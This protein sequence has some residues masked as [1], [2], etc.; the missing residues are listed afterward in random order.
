[1]ADNF[2]VSGPSLEREEG[3]YLAYDYGDRELNPLELM[4]DYADARLFQI[5][6]E[7]KGWLGTDRDVKTI[8]ELVERITL[9]SG[10]E[11]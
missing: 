5:A 10:K 8:E 3:F 4:R 2:G 6:S 7:L 11:N 1:M 9:E